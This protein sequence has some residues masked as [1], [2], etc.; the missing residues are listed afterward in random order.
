MGRV[1]QRSGGRGGVEKNQYVGVGTEGSH[2][3]GTFICKGWEVSGRIMRRDEMRTREGEGEGVKGLAG[4]AGA[5]VGEG[6]GGGGPM[7]GGDSAGGLSESGRAMS[8]AK[9]VM[10]RVREECVTRGGWVGGT[11]KE[12]RRVVRVEGGSRR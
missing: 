5:K 7:G 11:S 10:N 2:G 9:G 6:G 3:G 12:G 4:S 1:G 8:T